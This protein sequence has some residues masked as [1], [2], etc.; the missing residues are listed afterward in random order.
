MTKPVSSLDELPAQLLELRELI[1]E[2]HK[3]MKDLTRVLKEARA[4]RDELPGEVVAKIDTAVKTGLDEYSTALTD[5]IDKATA[6]VFRRFD[7]LAAICLGEDPQSV[8]TGVPTVPDLLR[9]YIKAKGLPYWL[10]KVE[11]SDD[12]AL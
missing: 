12:Q 6:K 2:G 8:R 5:A 10:A 9:G 1:T 4:T 3:L 11:G 7:Q